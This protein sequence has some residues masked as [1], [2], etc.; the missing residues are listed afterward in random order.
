MKKGI[1]IGA[2]VAGLAA[3]LVGGAA[4]L[5]GAYAKAGWHDGPDGW[6]VLGMDAGPG[7]G[8]GVRGIAMLEQF[9][10][11]GDGQVSQDDIDAVRG[12]RLAAFDTDGD[13]V[14]SLAEYQLLW[15]D[16]M[17]PRMVR[18]FQRLDADG[19]AIVTVDEFQ[20]PFAGM[21]ARLDADGDGMINSTELRQTMRARHGEWRGDRRDPGRDPLPQ[22]DD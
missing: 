19:D 7:F 11:S 2:V 6:A 3:T 18:S 5:H 13:G 4:L 1:I 12:E 16:A 10:R 20:E 17:R 21:V 14:L 9:D 8:P 22:A 15:L